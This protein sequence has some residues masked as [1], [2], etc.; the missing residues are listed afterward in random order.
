MNETI[1]IQNYIDGSAEP[2]DRLLTEAKLLINPLMRENLDWQKTTHKL[3]E[4]YGRKQLKAEI[5][6]VEK[7]L[8]SETKF[9][10]FKKS[11]LNIF[12]K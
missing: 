4:A 2:A 3:V 5:S 10:S 9:S 12:K 11:I 8:F 1:E 7:R 6:R